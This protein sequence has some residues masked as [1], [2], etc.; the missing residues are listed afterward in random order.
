MDARLVMYVVCMC[1][2]T[3]VCVCVCVRARACGCGFVHACPCLVWPLHI[4]ITYARAFC[5]HVTITFAAIQ[6]DKL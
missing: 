3:C 6:F 4:T 2:C 5:Q 1:I